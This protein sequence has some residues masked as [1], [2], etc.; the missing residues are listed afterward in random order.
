MNNYVCK[1]ATLDEVA[2]M[3]D[4]YIE[5]DNQRENWIKWKKDA[6][7]NQSNGNTINY[8]GLL[9]GKVIC[10]CTAAIA[11]TNIQNAEGLIDENTA[12]LLAFRTLPEYRGKGYFTPLFDFM[13][14]DLRNRGYKK[15][16][17]GVE[18]K[19]LKNKAIYDH[20]G[21]TEYIKSSKE[22]NPDGTVIEIEYYGKTL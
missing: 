7:Y 18:P 1:I 4:F 22:V 20:Y 10:E 5:H 9:D 11:T 16:T 19:E 8:H 13:L 2:A 15:V 12:Y 6:L 14:D 17:L 21:F 3:F